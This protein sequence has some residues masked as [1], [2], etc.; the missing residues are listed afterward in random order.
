MGQT[1]RFSTGEWAVAAMYCR[2]APKP[3]R[4]NAMGYTESL[5]RTMDKWNPTWKLQ[6]LTEAVEAQMNY[7]RGG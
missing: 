7:E 6:H 2:S 3:I 1:I 4:S 5:M